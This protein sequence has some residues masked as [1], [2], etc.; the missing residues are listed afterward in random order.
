MGSRLPYVVAYLDFTEH[1]VSAVSRFR[2]VIIVVFT[3]Q[4]NWK[5]G[6]KIQKQERKIIKRKSR[7]DVPNSTQT[8]KDKSDGKY[9]KPLPTSLLLC[10]KILGWMR[11]YIF[12]ITFI[13]PWP[14]TFW[15][16]FPTSLFIFN[17]FSFLYICKVID[18]PK[19]DQYVWTYIA[20]MYILFRAL[21]KYTQ[22]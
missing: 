9:T 1:L 6:Q 4:C 12:I 21:H 19:C 14:C 3:S 8:R 17:D 22:Q 10:E 7:N 15:H 5:H 2:V 13:L 16:A 11:L 18:I 20:E